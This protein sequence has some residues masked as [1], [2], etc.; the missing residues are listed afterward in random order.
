MEFGRGYDFGYGPRYQLPMVVPM[1]VGTG[2][3]LAKMWQTARSR[4][5]VTSALQA[6]GPVALAL[7]AV[8][9]GVVRIAPYLY[10]FNY[11]DV[12]TH[13]RLHD[14]IDEVKPH[15]AIVFGGEGLNTTDPMDLTE[16]LPLDLYP[17]Q[18][19]LVAIDRGPEAVRCVRAQYPGWNFYHAI[20]GNP[21]HI[22][23][24]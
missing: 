12:R 18:D 14:A 22:V 1:A 6:G 4:A 16:N 11:H 9:L 23:R 7:G 15:H 13:N 2:V 5:V 17:N 20:P 3:V 19:V 10:P 8:F 24:Y 21:V